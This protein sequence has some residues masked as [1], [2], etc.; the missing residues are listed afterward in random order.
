MTQ[1]R[2]ASSPAVRSFP[3]VMALRWA[4]S[5]WEKPS[6]T[7]MDTVRPLRYRAC[8]ASKARPSRGEENSRLS[9]IAQRYD[10]VSGERAFRDCVNVILE[11]H[12][13]KSSSNT[14][15]DLIAIAA[16]LKKNKGYGGN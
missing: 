1:S 6:S 16:K 8:S 3:W 2:K 13:R 10:K 14:E 4:S 11:E 5:A 15:E 12:G 7:A 9:A